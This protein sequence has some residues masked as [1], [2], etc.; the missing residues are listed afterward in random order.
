MDTNNGKDIR[1]T[2]IVA[3][4]FRDWKGLQAII[5]HPHNLMSAERGQVVRRRSVRPANPVLFV[6]DPEANAFRAS[7]I[8]WLMVNHPIK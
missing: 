6:D 7:V 8:E 4:C 2:P 1:G 5:H 3:Q